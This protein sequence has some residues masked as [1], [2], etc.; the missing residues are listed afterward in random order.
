MIQFNLLPAV[1]LEFVKARRNRRLALLGSGL[2]SGASLLVLFLLFAGV[3]LQAKHSRDLSRDISSESKKLES[4]EDISSILT[5]QNQL[6]SLSTLHAS[7]PEAERVA[8]YLKQV[9]PDKVTISSVKA[10]FE[11]QTMTISGKAPSAVLVNSYIDTLKFATFTTSENTTETNAF[12]EVVLTTVSPNGE[13]GSVSYDLALKF[14]KIIFSNQTKVNLVVPSR[15]TTR[16][17][18]DKPDAV[19]A[20]REDQ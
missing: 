16:S 3:Q 19:F 18:L 4:V 6:N 1:K 8:T 11:A 15:E 10:D 2:L 9:T 12:T 20:P 13:D 7:K 14:D 17:Q 5:V